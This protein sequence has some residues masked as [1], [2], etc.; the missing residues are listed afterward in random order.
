VSEPVAPPSAARARRVLAEAIR[1][2]DTLNRIDFGKLCFPEQRAFVEDDSPFVA[3]EAGRR[4]GKSDGAVL[5]CLRGA[6]ENPNSQIPYIALSRPHAKR[7]AWPKFLQWNRTL[8]LDAKFNHAE[9][10][11]YLPK[12][13]STITLGGAND[14]GEIERYRGGAYPLVVIDEAQAFRSFLESFVVEI[15]L[16]ATLDYDGQIVLIGTPNAGCFGYFHDAVTGELRNDEG[17]PMF[18][19]HHWTGFQN[20]NLDREFREGKHQDVGLALRR[21]AGAIA[22]IA[23]AAGLEPSDPV[24]R[25]EYLAEWV[26]DTDGLVYQVKKFST[27]HSLPDADDWVYVLGMDVG[28]VDATAFVVMAYSVSLGRCVV[29]ESFQATQMLPSAQAA[30]VERLATRYEFGSIVIDPGGGGK[31]LVEELKQRHDIPAT[32][33]EKK[34]KVAAIGT[35]NGD[36]RAGTCHIIKATNQELLHDLSL[37]QWNYGKLRR[38]GGSQWRLKPASHLE[39]DDRTPDHLSDAFLYAHRECAHHLNEGEREGPTPG[40]PAWVAEQEQELFDVI[41]RGVDAR[42]RPWW[43]G[44]GHS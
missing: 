39:I 25:R 33:A 37:L 34:Q 14:E 42:Q 22:R 19:V 30:A 44:P 1:R 12:C 7:I 40:T 23:S 10:S 4:G 32:V 24:Y 2:A 21:V 20:P 11:M 15:L 6:H 5:K 3:G 38:R 9:L 29:V 35:L 36:L 26:R 27:I 43:E 13:G 41:S 18:S 8:G 16:P 31:G 28:F 17:D